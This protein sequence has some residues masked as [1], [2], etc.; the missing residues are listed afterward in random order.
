MEGWAGFNLLKNDP[1]TRHIP[2]HII[3]VEEQR[4]R[5]LSQGAFG[6][7]V[8]PTTG[9]LLSAGLNR[10]KAY[11]ERPVKPLPVVEDNEVQ[12]KA[13][14]ELLRGTG[15]AITLAA[16]GAEALAA[17]KAG[18]FD[19]LVLDLKH[20]DMSASP[21][22]QDDPA[23]PTCRSSFTPARSSAAARSATCAGDP[24]HHRQGRLLPSACSTR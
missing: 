8:K 19:C 5:G 11:I 23:S 20:P 10:M 22:A 3:S 17:L 21:D 9:E 13:I 14:P 7:L 12:R 16:T 4:G 6:Y 1:S 2:I 18:P 24:V 15:V